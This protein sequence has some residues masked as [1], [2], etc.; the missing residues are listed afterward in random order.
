MESEKR[1][2]ARILSLMVLRKP[3]NHN[4]IALSRPGRRSE[5]R[6]CMLSKEMWSVTHRIG[7]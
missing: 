6:M 1:V 4:G 2:L 7:V 5:A 3:R